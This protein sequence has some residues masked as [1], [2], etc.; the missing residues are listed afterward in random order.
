MRFFNELSSRSF[1]ACVFPSDLFLAH[2]LPTPAIRV[3]FLTIRKINVA[4][5]FA[6]FVF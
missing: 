4:Y 6:V 5:I 1:N 3:S 2:S